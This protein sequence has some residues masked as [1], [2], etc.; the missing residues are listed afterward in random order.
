MEPL[1]S[2]ELAET[3]S[4]APSTTLR[5]EP[6][7]EKRTY[8]FLD[9]F[10]LPRTEK[11]RAFVASVIDRLEAREQALKLRKRKRKEAD[12]ASWEEDVA[13]LMCDLARLV[14]FDPG[15]SLGVSLRHGDGAGT[16]YEQGL[17][18]KPLKR[19]V[20]AIAA[21]GLGLIEVEKGRRV[22]KPRW[23]GT[24]G[25]IHVPDDSPTLLHPAPS[26]IAEVEVLELEPRTSSVPRRRRSLS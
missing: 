10:W 21:D 7:E 16:R 6:G 18:G 1:T 8:R 3:A 13:A 9:R 15:K 14:L 23:T 5:L 17:K 25:L 26:F 11:A 2:T 20:N 12:R 4:T 24:A 19:I 22:W